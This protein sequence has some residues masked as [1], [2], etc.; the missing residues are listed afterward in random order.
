MGM[1]N[2]EPVCDAKID[3]GVIRRGNRHVSIAISQGHY[4]LLQ[5][6]ANLETVFN[7][8]LDQRKDFIRTNLS[9][10][11]AIVMKDRELSEANQYLA[12]AN[13]KLDRQMRTDELTG[14]PNMREYVDNLPHFAD[15][16][17][18]ASLL[19]Q[20]DNLSD[21]NNAYGRDTGNAFVQRFASGIVREFFG[22]PEHWK[23]YRT[24]PKEF[25]VIGDY[26]ATEGVLPFAEIVPY[27]YELCSVFTLKLNELENNELCLRART[28]ISYSDQIKTDIYQ[29]LHIAMQDTSSGPKV[30]SFDESRHSEE[31]VRRNLEGGTAVTEAMK[32][33]RIIPYYQAIINNRT[34]KVEK[35]E[36]LARMIGKDGEVYPPA[37]FINHAKQAGTI[38]LLTQLMF[39]RA[40][41]DFSGLETKF[42]I[43]ISWQDLADPDLVRQL[44]GT[45]EKYDV[46]PGR[47]TLEILEEALLT[48]QGE[49][50]PRIAELK[51]IGCKIAL[52]DFGSEGSNFSRFEKDWWPDIIKIDGPSFIRGLEKSPEKQRI[53][54]AIV[55]AAKELG[56]EIVAEFVDSDEAWRLV[57]E[58]GIEY[59]QGYR[60]H[61]PQGLAPG[62][63]L[64]DAFDIT[65]MQARVRTAVADSVA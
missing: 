61:E 16:P 43:N 45:M 51:R 4:L 15:L 11:L 33:R 23:V 1:E 63:S 54:R 24:A 31:R 20:I 26:R 17:N 18:V 52:D 65:E 46:N 35:Y 7:R 42:S 8:I 50:A 44:V 29:K 30:V 22:N 6:P 39:E 12:A 37:T 10:L 41:Q 9:S 5:Y 25:L 27:F 38:P 13:A 49:Y 53:V 48:N 3:P 28:S 34:G 47:V 62:E 14:L 57:A 60:F 56:C 36:C 59:S 19:V 40:C 64:P 55:K 32:E 58:M 2:C 21:I